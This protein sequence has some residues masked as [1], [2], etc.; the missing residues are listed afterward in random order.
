[1]HDN[2]LGRW[3]TYRSPIASKKIAYATFHILNAKR[4]VR[5]IL[6]YLRED[7]GNW[8][9]YDINRVLEG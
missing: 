2:V 6:Q 4:S 1:M 9:W 5:I 7:S 8:K 3:V